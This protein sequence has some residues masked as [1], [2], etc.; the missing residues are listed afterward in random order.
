[1]NNTFHMSFARALLTGVSCHCSPEVQKEC[2]DHCASFHYKYAVEKDGLEQYAG[3]LNGFIDLAEREWGWKATVDEKNG[4]LYVDEGKNYCAC[5]LAENADGKIPSALCECSC[6]FI[7]KLFSLVL[8][9]EVKAI[10]A[11]SFLRDGKT[12][13]YEVTL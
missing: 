9:R 6:I 1:M 5:P 4:K 13:I 10:V 11:R 3:D 8:Q 12:C 2:F 7:G